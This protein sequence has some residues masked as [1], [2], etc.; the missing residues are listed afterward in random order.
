MVG[1]CHGTNQFSWTTG[2]CAV[3]EL[4]DQA[5]PSL[6]N[7]SKELLTQQLPL[8]VTLEE[9]KPGRDKMEPKIQD[10]SP[11]R[12]PYVRFLLRPCPDDVPL[13]DR[14]NFLALLYIHDWKKLAAAS[15]CLQS[16][17]W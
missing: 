10:P 7:D 15:V 1:S 9:E 8:T 12:R 13:E 17:K 14:E 6:I 4:S 11:F 3:W 2:Y 16:S 5:S